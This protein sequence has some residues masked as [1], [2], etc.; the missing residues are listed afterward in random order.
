MSITAKKLKEASQKKIIIKDEKLGDLDFEIRA[1]ST[2]E[3]SEI[4]DVFEKLPKGDPEKMSEDERR[5]FTKEVVLP[6][7]KQILPLCVVSPTI[8]LDFKDPALKDP[9]SDVIHLSHLQIN[10]SAALFNEILSMSGLTKEA[11][12]VKKKLL[13]AQLPKQ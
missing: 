9:E 6:M 3:L 2:Y 4:S 11:D 5:K 8:T 7:T 12:E 10:T 13:E 1:M